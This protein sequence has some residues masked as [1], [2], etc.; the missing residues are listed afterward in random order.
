MTVEPVEKRFPDERIRRSVARTLRENV[1]CSMST[2]S[3]GNRPHINTA[4]FCYTP[5]L[6]L[7]FLSDPSSQH[8]R[9]LERNAGLAMTIFRSAQEWGGQDRGIQLFGLCRRTSGRGARDA[10]RCYAAR[11]PPYAKWMNGLSPTERRQAALLHSYAFYRFLPS[12]IK[13]LDEAEFG[14]AAFVIAGVKR[15]RPPN[16]R[17]PIAIVTWLATEKLRPSGDVRGTTRAE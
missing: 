2:V 3:P 15:R 14:G 12:R 8:C 5:D 10:E 4:Y 9:N 6:E 13:I 1:L 11:F 16:R 17:T 7:Y